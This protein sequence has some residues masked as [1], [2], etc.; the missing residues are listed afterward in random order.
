MGTFYN[1]VGAIDNPLNTTYFGDGIKGWI[2]KSMTRAV[3]ATA[4]IFEQ[5]ETL[6][7]AVNKWDDFKAYVSTQTEQLTKKATGWM[8]LALGIGVAW[9]WRESTRGEPN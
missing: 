1:Q 5:S 9:L 3:V 8:W 7:D 6:T 4:Q 2:A